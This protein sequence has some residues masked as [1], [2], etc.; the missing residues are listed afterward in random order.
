MQ[1]QD[2]FEQLRALFANELA[3]VDKIMLNLSEHEYEGLIKSISRNIY[4]AGGKRIRPLLTFAVGTLFGTSSFTEDSPHTCLAAAVEFLHTATLLHDDVVDESLKRRGVKTANTLWGNKSA[5]LVGDFLFSKSF[6]LMLKSNSIP[7]LEV[8]ANAA[9]EITE[10]EVNQLEMIGKFDLT[11]N[12]YMSIIQA[13]TAELFAS[14]CEVGAIASGASQKDREAI[15]RYGYN[16]GVC[17][18]I[19]DDMLDY[20]AKSNQFGKKLGKDF[21]EK[22]ITIPLIFACQTSKDIRKRIIKLIS[23]QE[24]KEEHFIALKMLL[25]EAGIKSKVEDYIKPFASYSLDALNHLQNSEIKKLLSNL[26][27][28]S[29]FREY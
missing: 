6:L 13:K 18:Q 1:G 5:I 9:T 23:I 11:L 28:Y 10:G 4:K 25:D 26:I 8:L 12:E 24:K 27:E 19:S 22:K 21:L 7:S 17:F 29:V 3:M 14:A 20:Y 15:R 16:L 2:N